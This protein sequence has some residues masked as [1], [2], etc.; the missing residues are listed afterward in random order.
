MT[1]SNIIEYRILDKEGDVVDN[2]K[3]NIKMENK[4]TNYWINQEDVYIPKL[5]SLN[6]EH[7]PSGYYFLC[8]NPEIGFY[9]TKR[10]YHLDDLLIFPD[11]IHGE[12]IKG[13]NQFWERKDKFKEYG[14]AYKRGILLHGRAGCGKS[15]MINLLV[16]EMVDN[17]NGFVFSLGSHGDLDLFHSYI[18]RFFG[19]IEKDRPIFV[20]IEDI[21]NLCTNRDTET[22]LLNVLDGLD[23]LENV[24]YVA[25]TNYIENL[26]ERI[27]NRPSRFD[28]RIYVPMPSYNDRKFYFEKKLKSKDLESINLELW[29]QETE[30]MSIAHLSELIKS[31]VI[32]GNPFE[33]VIQILKEMNDFKKLHSSSYEKQ[34]STIGF[35][36]KPLGEKIEKYVEDL[37]KVERV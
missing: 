29:V 1:S 16:K 12:I 35:R 27:I 7:I 19:V 22:V 9:V 8:S 33:E 26:K 25:T 32:F 28:R 20:I 11:S 4:R 10:E 5:N 30:G 15:C 23:Q 34:T 3:Q 37:K 14:F 17:L 6:L 24:V 21:E 13:I 36:E 2:H 18:P 31:V